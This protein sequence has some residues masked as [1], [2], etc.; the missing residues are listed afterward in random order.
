MSKRKTDVNYIENTR[1]SKT[2]LKAMVPP[3]S[4]RD[5]YAFDETGK[6]V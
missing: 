6:R 5:L 1:D 2:I 4:K 3:H